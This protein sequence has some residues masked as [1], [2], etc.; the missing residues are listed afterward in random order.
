M[1]TTKIHIANTTRAREYRDDPN[2]QAIFTIKLAN[3]LLVTNSRDF[4]EI[5]EAKDYDEPE[6]ITK[7]QE[8]TARARRA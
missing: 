7:I 3:G 4:L 2:S 1:K 5:P 8:E 6:E